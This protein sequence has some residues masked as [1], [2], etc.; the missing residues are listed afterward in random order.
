MIDIEALLPI[1]SVVRLTGATKCTMIYGVRQWS[2]E[3]EK[4]FDYI[5]VL[6][7]EGN[8]GGET[9]IL[10]NHEDIE[11]VEFRGYETDDRRIFLEKLAAF[12]AKES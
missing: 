5:G 6:W 11:A 10:F 12:Y 1:G 9:Q 8:I 7:P 3:H 4:E 2:M